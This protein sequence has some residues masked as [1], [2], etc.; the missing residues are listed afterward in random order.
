MYLNTK[1]LMRPLLLC[2]LFLFLMH[3]CVDN[4]NAES[5]PNVTAH[6]WLVAD[7]KGHI[8]EGFNSENIRSIASITKLLTVMT[9]M[10]AGQALEETIITKKFKKITRQE[11]INLTIVRSDNTAAMILCQQYPGGYNECIH[12]MNRKAQELS[13]LDTRIY[14]ST[15]L[16]SNNVSTAKDLLNMVQAA[17]L[18]P[19]IVA[20]SQ[21]DQI[22]R[23]SIIYRNTNPLVG[24]GYDF[25]VSKTGFINKSGGCIVMM[26]NTLNGTRTV[27]LLGSKNTHT[28]IPEAA[29]ISARY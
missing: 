10:D 27:V 12:M 22:K 9:I 20:A 28:R 25:I 19:V 7:D 29:L 17:S 3:S 14:D 11:L 21:I 8:I 18:Y 6:A 5:G 23:R 26:L 24:H 4:A 15:G 16:N 13:M 1:Y 2:I